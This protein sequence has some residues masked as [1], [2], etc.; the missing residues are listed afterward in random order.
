MRQWRAL[1]W[2]L[3]PV[4]HRRLRPELQ[5]PKSRRAI[6][7]HVSDRRTGRAVASGKVASPSLQLASRIPADGRLHVVSDHIDLNYSELVNFSEN[8][9]TQA[10]PGALRGIK[11]CFKDLGDSTPTDVILWMVDHQEEE[12]AR[13]NLPFN[14]LWGRPLHAID[15]QG[16]FCETDKY[17]REA[18][19]GLASAR[20]RIKARFTE[21]P[22]PLQLFFPIKWGISKKL[23]S[24]LVFGKPSSRDDSH[25]GSFGGNL[26]KGVAGQAREGTGAVWLG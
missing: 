9:F 16:L 4:C 3:Y 19:P 5:A 24:R 13:L 20:K 25:D 1:Y 6:P 26:T 23:P 2:R 8:E 15:A 14:G 21:T 11:K 22:E 18:A 10:S 7:A 12:F 17:C